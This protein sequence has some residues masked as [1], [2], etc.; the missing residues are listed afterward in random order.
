M[1]YFQPIV[2]GEKTF[3]LDHLEPFTFTFTSVRAKRDLR[4]HVTFTNHCFSEKFEPEEAIQESDESGAVF[5]DHA[6]RLR[7]FCEVRYRLSHMLPS[8]IASLNDPRIKVSETAA[9]RNWCYTMR[10]EDPVGPY[11]VFFE[12]R[13]AGKVALG[14]QELNLIVESAYHQD[15]QRPEPALKGAM[16]FHLLCTKI[17]LG[18]RTSTRR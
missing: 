13:R 14:R 5:P 2:V 8:V 6:N 15:P 16:S 1:P 3:P 12:V 4:V 11:Y 10:I 18:E 9:E 17:F 7:I